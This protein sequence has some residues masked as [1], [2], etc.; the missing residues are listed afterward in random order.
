MGVFLLVLANLLL[1]LVL[2]IVT[3][4]KGKIWTGLLGLFL[5]P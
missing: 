1:N 4:F 2:A 5:A 3:L